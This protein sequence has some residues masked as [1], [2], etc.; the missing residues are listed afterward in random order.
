[1]FISTNSVIWNDNLFYGTVVLK[2]KVDKKKGIKIIPHILFC[3]LILI[4]K[5]TST[6]HLSVFLLS[7]EYIFVYVFNM[8]IY[9]LPLLY[10]FFFLHFTII[11]FLM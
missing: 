4:L 2:S 3:L 5:I 7:S 8:D 11:F 9:L 1:M 6:L 10:A